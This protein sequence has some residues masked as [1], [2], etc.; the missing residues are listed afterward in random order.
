MRRFE[1]RLMLLCVT[2]AA[3]PFGAPAA[4][5]TLPETLAKMD[6]AAARFKGFSANMEHLSH[7]DVIHEEEMESGVIL[8]KRPKP[9]DVH[10]RIE[11]QKP[12][13]KVVVTDSTKVEVYYPRSGQIDKFELGR[14]RSLVDMFVAQGF[15]G[16]SADMA[17]D[18]SVKL[19]GAEIVAGENA[20][21][22]E[23]VPK[24]DV[25]LEQYK[26]VDLWISDK[27]GYTL[28]QKFYERNGKDYHVITYT[29][30]KI[31]PEIPDSAFKL[32]VPK[33]TKRETVIKK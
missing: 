23:L 13:P 4:D 1:T 16:T 17:K 9:K 14:R 29:N 18:Y 15:G 31:N 30:V 20:T 6:E 19:G 7:F 21:R 33:G 11:L 25:M 27:S 10:I 5:R 8:M 3:T 26:R 12:E 28:Q 22:L 32:E 24:S 2:I